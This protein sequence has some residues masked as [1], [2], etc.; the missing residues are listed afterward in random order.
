MLG[1]LGCFLAPLGRL[2]GLPL[3]VSGRPLPPAAIGVVL[4]VFT[5][6]KKGLISI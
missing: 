3:P 4:V 2:L 5:C 6:I 1:P